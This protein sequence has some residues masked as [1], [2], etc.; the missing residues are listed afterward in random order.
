MSKLRIV[1][2]RAVIFLKCSIMMGVISGMIALSSSARA[3]E[4]TL[5]VA[6]VYNF[7]KFIDWPAETST[8]SS[9]SPSSLPSSSLRLCVLGAN[10]EMHE[11]LDQ[12]NGKSANKQTIELVYLNAESLA[13]TPLENCE[14]VFRSSRS[15]SMILPNPL[16]K[17]VVLVTNEQGQDGLNASIVLMR[18]G[19]GRIEFEINQSAVTQAGVKISSQLL[20]LAKNAQ[21]GKNPL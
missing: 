3:S 16:P 13:S 21:V 12:L 2:D 7:I 18:N 1:L 8:L 19:E 15:T 17:G 10:K 14:M 9:S 6:F 5:Q 20:K 4:V 11:A